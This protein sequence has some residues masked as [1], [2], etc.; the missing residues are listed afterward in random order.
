MSTVEHILRHGS[1]TAQELT[2]A[3]GISQPTLS[4]RIRDVAENVLVIGKGKATRYAQ[5][6]RI[7]EPFRAIAAQMW[8]QLQTLNERIQR[9]A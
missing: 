8:Q 7:S 9:L 6:P 5:H 4:R 3:L 1:A 2:G